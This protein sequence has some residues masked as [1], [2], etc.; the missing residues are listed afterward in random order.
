MIMLSELYH[1]TNLI[2]RRS[3]PILGHQAKKSGFLSINRS[4]HIFYLQSYPWYVGAGVYIALTKP[5]KPFYF[6]KDTSLSNGDAFA[7]DTC[8]NG[9][10]TLN[11]GEALLLWTK[12]YVNGSVAALLINNHPSNTYDNISVSSADVG[13]NSSREFQVMD[14]WTGNIVGFSKNGSFF[15]SMEPRDSKLFVLTPMKPP[16]C[17]SDFDCSLASNCLNGSCN[18]ENCTKGSALG[19]SNRGGY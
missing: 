13:L 14:V 10:P 15:T 3:F 16:K 1:A 8:L 19:M 6:N 7:Q 12:P 2:P 5:H 17:L 11:N 9:S 4:D 18:C